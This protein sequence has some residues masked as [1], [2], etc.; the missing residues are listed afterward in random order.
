MNGFLCNRPIGLRIAVALLL[1]VLGLV[2]FSGAMVLERRSVMVEMGTLERLAAVAP[3]ISAVV[4]ELQKERGTSAGFIGAKGGVFSAPL[5]AQRRDTEAALARLRTTLEAF[6]SKAYGADFV[7]RL[8]DQRSRLDGLADVRRKV[9]TFEMPMTEM[10]GWYTTTISG[11]LDVVGTMGT[12][13]GDADITRSITGYIAFLQAKERSGIERAMGSNGFSAGAFAP[14]VYQRFVG[15]IAEQQA[16]LSLFQSFAS[17]SLITALDGV[18]AAAPAKDV[19]RMRSVALSSPQTGSTAGVAGAEWF[20]TITAKIDGLKGVEDL[21][22]NALMEQARAAE[23]RAFSAFLT[24]LAVVVVLLAATAVLVTIVVRGITQPI[25]LLTTDMGL[26]ADGDRTVAIDGI[27][28]GDE[29]GAMSRAVQVFKD[30]MIHNDHM[31]E[32]QAREQAARVAR[33]ERLD[34]L[35]QDFDAGVSSLLETVASATT[36]LEASAGSM[37]A[38]AEETSAQATSV[39]AAAEEASGNVQTVA[40]AAEELTASI[41]EIGRQVT[42][43][44]SIASAAAD[45]ARETDELVRGLADAANR[46]G[47]VVAL[48]T[49]IADQTN[50]L[51]LNATIEAARAG[52]AGKGFAVVANEVK[53]LASQTA[54][55]TEDIRSQIAGVQEETKH[56]AAAIGEIVHVVQRVNEVSAAIASAVEEQNAATQEIS[57]N[58]QEAA[59]GTQSVSYTIQGVTTAAQEAGSASSQVQAASSQVANEAEGLRGMVQTFLRDVRSA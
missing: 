35:T 49:D 16:F 1:P 26:L 2:F 19:E 57:R 4:H 59:N 8:S 23:A 11:L 48:I 28:R 18:L 9:S 14:P 27:E 36:E 7:R 32:E 46:I 41:H 51:A 6:D 17:P 20:T 31:Q 29:I 15:L 56:A 22:A 50:L 34:K 30:A 39:A 47:E 53:Q 13:S 45:K 21:A 38:I 37:S 42:E 3:D 54:R 55:A 24:T 43:S 25:A 40:S 58:V 44:A 33:A 5:D 10:A 52:D 12:L